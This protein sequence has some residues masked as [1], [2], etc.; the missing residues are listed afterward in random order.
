MAHPLACPDCAKMYVAAV[1]EYHWY[2]YAGGP[3]DGDAE[4]LGT[5]HYAVCATHGERRVDARKWRALAPQRHVEERR[6]TV[7]HDE[8]R[9]L[10]EGKG[11][12][13]YAGEWPL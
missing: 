2:R 13:D 9:W 12:E 3:R 4:P 6:R 1:T 11:Y 10:G 5:V 8:V 7:N